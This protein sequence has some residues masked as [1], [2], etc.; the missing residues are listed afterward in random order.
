VDEPDLSKGWK[1][2][3]LVCAV[4]GG[5]FGLVTFAALSAGSAVGYIGATLGGIT[6]GLIV[7]SVIRQLFD[8]FRF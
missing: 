2:L 6:L 8:S 5:V 4:L 1:R 7:A 3:L